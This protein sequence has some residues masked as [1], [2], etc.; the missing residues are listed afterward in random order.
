MSSAARIRNP[1]GSIWSKRQLGLT[2]RQP[3]GIFT[4][5][6]VMKLHNLTNSVFGRLVVIRQVPRTTDTRW[7]CHCSCGNDVTVRAKNLTRG[8]TRSCGC[9]KDELA[10]ERLTT[11]GLSHLAEYKVWSVARDRCR[12]PRN[13]KFKNYGGRGIAM[14][15]EWDAGFASFY[16][17]MGL[18]PS[19][20]HTLER[21]D[22]NGP[23]APGNCRWATHMEQARNQRRNRRV[24]VYGQSMVLQDADK[25]AP[26]RRQTIEARLKSG[27][28]MHEA[29]HHPSRTCK[30]RW[31]DS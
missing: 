12:N 10:A 6:H 2:L 5:L 18:R 23:Y 19:S 4:P 1:A 29:V 17:D 30:R 11:H 25:I 22:N 28:S 20:Q 7:Q 31:L 26:V 3:N 21:I 15:P 24:V 8:Q 13:K 27:Q 14:C 16:A 9:L